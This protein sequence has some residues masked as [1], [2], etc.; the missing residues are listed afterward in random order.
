MPPIPPY[1]YPS[2]ARSGPGDEPKR[3]PVQVQP[4]QRP[5]E[6]IRSNVPVSPARPTKPFIERAPAPV[7][8][9]MTI[10]HHYPETVTLPPTQEVAKRIDSPKN[11]KPNKTIRSI[12][13]PNNS[14][15]SK[16][17]GTSTNSAPEPELNQPNEIAPFEKIGKVGRQR[18]YEERKNGINSVRDVV[19]YRHVKGKHYP[20]LSSDMRRW[21]EFFYFREPMKGEKPFNANTSYEQHVEA[22]ERGQDWIRRHE[23]NSTRPLGHSGPI[24]LQARR[25]AH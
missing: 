14:D 20:G 3:K 2:P 24:D 17:S 4:Y 11:S 9:P 12:R 1:E 19:L 5:P 23:L 22:Y 21:Y 6:P 8:Q 13:P 25:A 16:N 15:N 18:K 7:Q 10:V